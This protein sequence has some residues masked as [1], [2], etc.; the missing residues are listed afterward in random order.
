VL[1]VG[2]DECACVKKSVTEQGR[3]IC[4]LWQTN[5]KKYLE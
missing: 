5:Y 4:G 2:I 3:E 1:V